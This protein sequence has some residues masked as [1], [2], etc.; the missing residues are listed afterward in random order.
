MWEKAQAFKWAWRIFAS[1]IMETK[2]LSKNTGEH[3]CTINLK[4]R[5]WVSQFKIVK[6]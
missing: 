3:A 4:E 1:L 6:S 5:S 2:H